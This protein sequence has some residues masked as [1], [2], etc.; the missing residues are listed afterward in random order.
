[1]F[2]GVFQQY[3]RF[4]DWSRSLRSYIK[5]RDCIGLEM[6]NRKPETVTMVT[7]WFHS[8][9]RKRYFSVEYNYLKS[10]KTNLKTYFSSP[11]KYRRSIMRFK[12]QKKRKSGSRV[13]FIRD[14][15]RNK[16]LDNL[17]KIKV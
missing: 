6:N 9:F 11:N 7:L 14:A 8:G 15:F 1:M 10:E 16:Y 5:R 12:F 17:I 3:F 2:I 4:G 13:L